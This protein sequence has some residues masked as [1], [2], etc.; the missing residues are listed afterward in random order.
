MPETKNILK[1]ILISFAILIAFSLAYKYY[2]QGP[3]A[4]VKGQ[5]SQNEALV[6]FEDGANKRYFAGEVA[7]N[8]TVLDA[9]Q[10]SAEMGGFDINTVDGGIAINRTTGWKFYLNG[11]QIPQPLNEYIIRPRDKIELRR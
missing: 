8:M 6:V 5:L 3:L 7:D 10:A 11:N 2:P 9:I 1:K 4:K